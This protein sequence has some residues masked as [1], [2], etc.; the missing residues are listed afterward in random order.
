MSA[1]AN[2]L[3][4]PVDVAVLDSTL[5]L[6]VLGTG[7]HPSIG[8]GLAV[9]RHLTDLGVAYVEAGAPGES[10]R[11]ATLFARARQELDALPTLV[12]HATAPLHDGAVRGLETARPDVVNLSV[13]TSRPWVERV[14][15]TAPDEY[16][17][18]VRS[19]VERLRS[20]GF[21]LFVD[22]EHAVDGWFAD[23]D[24]ARRVLAEC[25]A[26]EVVSVVDT[27]GGALPWDVAT[28]VGHLAAVVPVVGVQCHDDA[29]CAT[30]STLAA[31]RAGAQ[32][33]QVTVNGYG[34][35]CGA[36]DLAAVVAGLETKLQRRCL[37]A[38]RLPELQRI[39]HAVAE[40]ANLVPE[41]HQPYVGTAAF[42]HRAGPAAA[43]V[44]RAP[45]LA[46]HVDPAAVG[47]DMT[48]LVSELAGRAGVELKARQLGVEVPADMA[49]RVIDVVRSREA[50]GYSYE[51]AEASFEL[52]LRAEVDGLPPRV[53][54]LES[55]RAIVERRADG[56][57]AAEATVKAYVDGRRV[58]A[59]GEGNG[60]VNAL[61]TAIRQ[62]IGADHPALDRMELVDY[63][64]RILDAGHG[65]GTAAITRVLVTTSDGERE[66]VTVG[67]GENVIDASWQALDDAYTYGLT[68]RRD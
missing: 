39:V 5:R 12:G 13:V 44:T 7:F 9:L 46:Q 57:L 29:G 64:V 25:A 48:L 14:L 65:S 40:T 51:A 43:A 24:F 59:T 49:G 2:P 61:D 32:L 10:P 31:V 58:V 27:L 33:V 54:D 62:A 30:A 63:K 6:G 52:L 17:E 4:L 47:N 15:D 16:V 55:W 38:G 22:A 53:F 34:S 19:A 41:P 68:L 8:D 42:A 67:A 28:V 1:R 20:E 35:R 36:A 56:E 21:R 23:D 26:A 60:P 18:Q 66:W 11:D 37:P 50:A 45:D 3:P